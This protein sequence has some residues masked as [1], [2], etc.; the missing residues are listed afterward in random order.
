[1]RDRKSTRMP[2]RS[3]G[4]DQEVAAE[5]NNHDHVATELTLLRQTIEQL[6]LGQI[7]TRNALQHQL[8]DIKTEIINT[9]DEKITR[10]QQ[11]LD[12]EMSQMT[13]RFE[14]VE[15]RITTVE[16]KMK[17]DFASEVTLIARNVLPCRNENLNEVAA[18]IIEEG[19]GL[20]DVDIIRTMRLEARGQKPGIV[21]I[22][23]K[24]T[25]DKIR[26]LRNKRKLMESGN[27]R[28]K[29]IC[30]Q[31]SRDHVK[32][33][34]EINMRTILREL[35]NGNTLRLTAGGRIIK[36]NRP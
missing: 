24:S 31:S 29:N 1:M 14:D 6:R 27:E 32:R 4:N 3:D 23:L 13:R 17:P 18:V 21:K 19:V 2:L 36:A 28:L 16:H 5:E 35:P 10:L 26:V 30:I 12:I 7:E 15:A 8:N 9:V 33:L 25:E 20:R 22:E 34:M 11:A